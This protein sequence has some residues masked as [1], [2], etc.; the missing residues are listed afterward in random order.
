MHEPIT[1]RMV[2]VPL[3]PR[4]LPRWLLKKIIRDAGMTDGDLRNL[5]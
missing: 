4:E 1:D 2:V 3:H 5:L